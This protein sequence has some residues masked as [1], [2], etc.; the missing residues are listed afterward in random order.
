MFEALE[1]GCIPVHI[2]GGALF[3]YSPAI[4]WQNLIIRLE[5]DFDFSN[6]TYLE[7][8]LLR[9]TPSTF[10]GG[11]G[12]I[13]EHHKTIKVTWEYVKENEGEVWLATVKV[14]WM[15]RHGLSNHGADVN[16]DSVWF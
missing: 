2:G 15:Q 8:E 10:K 6:I 5:S 16:S 14:R 4:A 11:E 12:Q 3:A 7:A 9:R 13:C 1:A